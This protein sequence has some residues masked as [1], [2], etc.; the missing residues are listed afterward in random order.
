MTEVQQFFHSLQ[1]KQVWVNYRVAK[2]TGSLV[3]CKGEPVIM[4][5][6]IEASPSRPKHE[7]L[8]VALYQGDGKFATMIRLSRDD[9]ILR[10][11]PK[12]FTVNFQD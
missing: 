3:K 4:A 11:E 2:A 9:I 1:S 8:L 12:H 10:K 6:V 7:E 5:R